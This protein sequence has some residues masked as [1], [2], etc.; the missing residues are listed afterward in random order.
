MDS[1]MQVFFFIIKIIYIM[2][3]HAI[4]FMQK[5]VRTILMKNVKVVMK[6]LFSIIKFVM[7]VHKIV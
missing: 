4:P 7:F 6:G 2:I 1:A 3:I 5:T